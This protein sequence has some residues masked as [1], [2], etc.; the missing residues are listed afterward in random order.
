MLCLQQQYIEMQRRVA[1]PFA[2]IML[3]VENAPVS[4]KPLPTEQSPSYL[5]VEACKDDKAAVLSLF[6]KM[7]GDHNT[8]RPSVGRTGLCI[9]STLVY[10]NSS[11]K[12]KQKKGQRAASGA[13]AAGAGAGGGG[14]VGEQNGRQVPLQGARRAELA[15]DSLFVVH[16]NRHH[17]RHRG[18]SQAAPIE[19]V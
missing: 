19:S 15:E 3:A 10:I 17:L 18:D 1:R 4:T 12:P 5:A 13:A 14:G 16:T 6:V 8:G 9:G 11:K 2:K 7:P